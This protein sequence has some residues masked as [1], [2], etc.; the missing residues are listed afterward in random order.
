MKDIGNSDYSFITPHPIPVEKEEYFQPFTED[1]G[2]TFEIE[3]MLNEEDLSV[4]E[5]GHFTD[6][7][8][9]AEDINEDIKMENIEDLDCPHT[10]RIIP[11]EIPEEQE[12]HQNPES[13]QPKIIIENPEMDEQIEFNFPKLE[14]SSAVDSGQ[15]EGRKEL[16]ES[17]LDGIDSKKEDFC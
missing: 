10:Q 9:T 6:E 13:S 16:N 12:I 3:P 17:M 5:G 1:E 8:F 15:R 4:E 7:G 11:E 14:L 2:V